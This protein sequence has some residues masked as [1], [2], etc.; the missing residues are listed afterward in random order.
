MPYLDI[1]GTK[2][3][4]ECTGEGSPPLA[5]VHGFAC[6]HEDWRYQ[7]E[8]FGKNNLAV[9]CDPRGHGRSGSGPGDCTIEMLSNDL[10]HL[11]GSLNIPP[12]V[13]VGHSMGCRVVLQIYNAMP[14]LVAGLIL[15]D[16]SRLATGNRRDA[17]QKARQAM[18]EMGY[19]A[20]MRHVFTSMFIKGNNAP[21]QASIIEKA[22]ALPEKVG[23]PLFA[24]LCGWDAEKMDQVLAQIRVPLLL[25]QSTTVNANLERVSLQPGTSTPWTELVRSHVPEAQ[26]EII[27]DTGHFPM[28]EAPEAVNQLI[29]S[30]LASS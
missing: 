29:A 8:H 2:L 25:I 13:L 21:W 24:S 4:Y 20:W 30:F 17:E 15:V 23:I 3:F 16:G 11:L 6:G 7:M 10:A 22:A 26:V 5:F 9:T 12:A 1:S 28:L 18:Q 27:G 19:A 14:G